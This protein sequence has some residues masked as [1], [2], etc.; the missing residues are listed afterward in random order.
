MPLINGVDILIAATPFILDRMLGLGWTNLERLHTLVFDN[1]YFLMEKYSTQVREF[2][3]SYELLLRNHDWINLAQ[4]VVVTPN[5][6]NKLAKFVKSVLA[7]PVIICE[8]K[9][10][11]AFYGKVHHV[12]MECDST[13]DKVFKYL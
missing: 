9:L 7:S 12:L 6:S 2:Q 3:R 13:H 8:S 11:A 4:I 1:G 10:E 5:W